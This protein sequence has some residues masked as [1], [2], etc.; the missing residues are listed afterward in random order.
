MKIFACSIY[1]YFFCFILLCAL[2]KI[3]QILKCICSNKPDNAEN[4]VSHLKVPTSFHKALL[5]SCSTKEGGIC[6][7]VLFSLYCNRDLCLDK[8]YCILK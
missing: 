8:F 7:F 4:S 5:C 6:V 3:M 1:F 2:T